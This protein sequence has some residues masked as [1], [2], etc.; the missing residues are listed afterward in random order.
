MSASIAINPVITTNAQ[1]SFLL[2]TSGY[3]AGT[4]LDDPG[5]RYQLE[6][7]VLGAVT[8]PCWGS[9]PI[10]LAVPAV[11]AATMLGSVALLAA[12]SGANINAWMVFNQASAGIQT[13][14]S[15]VPQY[16]PG[17]SINF[18]RVGCGLRLVLPVYATDVATIAGAAP[19][20]DL[21]WDFTNYRITSTAGTGILPVIAESVHTNGKIP[22]YNSGTGAVNWST[23]PVIVVRI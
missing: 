8:Q 3:V 19:T 1:N 21:Y 13:A 23:G 10:S 2:E 4:Y 5:L 18:L 14:T 22:V 7:G 17:M 15:S 20:I 6:G 12:S 16:L 11:G 9:L